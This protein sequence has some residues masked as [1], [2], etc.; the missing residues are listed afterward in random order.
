MF[1]AFTCFIYIGVIVDHHCLY[2]LFIPLW[3]LET[4]LL[5]F[6]LVTSRACLHQNIHVCIDLATKC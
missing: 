4:F 1:N 3:C 6:I 5:K 2:V